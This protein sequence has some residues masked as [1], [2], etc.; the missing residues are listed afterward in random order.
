MD[1]LSARPYALRHHKDGWRLTHL[2]S[3]VGGPRDGQ[4]LT[5]EADIR[6][7]AE[8]V[9]A[10]RDGPAQHDLPWRAGPTTA[11]SQTLVA[12]VIH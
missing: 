12:D 9:L 1:A 2:L 6:A 11:G 5:A 4:D 8:Q 3:I 10:H 7:W